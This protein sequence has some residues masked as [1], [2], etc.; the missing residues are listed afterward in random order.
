MR[1]TALEELK[2]IE[3]RLLIL[4]QAP[5][6]EIGI[7]TGSTVFAETATDDYELNEELSSRFPVAVR[8]SQTLYECLVYAL[9]SNLYSVRAEKKRTKLLELKTILYTDELEDL[10]LGI[11]DVPEAYSGVAT[12]EH[13]KEVLAKFFRL[14]ERELQ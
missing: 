7:E 10:C 9:A 11:E 1:N 4:N 13:L 6:E 8:T 12:S 3:D 5:V 14:I 2:K